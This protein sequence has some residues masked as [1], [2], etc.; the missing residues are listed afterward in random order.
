[1]LRTGVD[2]H[3]SLRVAASR[4]A[5]TQGVRGTARICSGGQ[6]EVGEA[7]LEWTVSV[8][9]R[10]C[11]GVSVCNQHIGS[12]PARGFMRRLATSSRVGV[13]IK[14][15]ALEGEGRCIWTS[16]DC[17]TGEMFRRQ[18]RA[19]AV[20]KPAFPALG[21]LLALHDSCPQAFLSLSIHLSSR[22]GTPRLKLS[23]FLHAL[24]CPVG[25]LL[26][27]SLQ[28]RPCRAGREIDVPT[29]TTGTRQQTKMPAA[30]S[31]WQIKT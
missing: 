23:Q 27:A 28:T 6:E 21:A 1:M 9:S 18:D 10:L 31:C 30:L 14:R 26:Q 2:G 11:L 22:V 13:L 5:A 29:R 7:G 20:V 24:L 4:W 17:L 16:R 3:L 25:F 12:R 8:W 15:W 19:F